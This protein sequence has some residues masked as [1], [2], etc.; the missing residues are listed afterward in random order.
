MAE[1]NRLSTQKIDLWFRA[2]S[3]QENYKRYVREAREWVIGWAAGMQD[4]AGESDQDDA[5]RAALG[6]AF[7]SISEYTPKALHAFVV[8]KCEITG[9]S[10][11][12]A[13][14]IRS[15]F[16]NYFM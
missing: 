14:G 12:T 5:D 7:D 9:L 1:L 6:L 13:E 16:K 11:K 2:Q 8:Y 15:A 3:T 10:Y 4:A